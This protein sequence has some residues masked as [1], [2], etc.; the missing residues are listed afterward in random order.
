MEDMLKQILT[1]VRSMNERLENVEKETSK[2][3]SIEKDVS[4]LKQDVGS[5]KQDLQNLKKG[6]ESIPAMQQAIFETNETVKDI[7]KNTNEK[8]N[9]H[10]LAIQALNRRLLYVEAKVE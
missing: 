1:E 9:E 5:L 6:Q 10:D 2:I 7:A 3:P 8:V 4:E